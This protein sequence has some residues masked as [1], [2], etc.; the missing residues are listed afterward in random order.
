M[1]IILHN[2]EE[3]NLKD[4]EEACILREIFN[5]IEAKKEKKETSN[6]INPLFEKYKIKN[7]K[8]EN[9]KDLNKQP[10]NRFKS[11]LQKM[12]FKKTL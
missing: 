10:K 4:N 1:S 8:L 6:K 3:N 5:I 9:M 7:I 11:K 12:L 2:T